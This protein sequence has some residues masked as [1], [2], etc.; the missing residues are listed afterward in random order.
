MLRFL[1]IVHAAL[2]HASGKY[3]IMFLTCLVEDGKDCSHSLAPYNPVFELLLWPLY[4]Y[5]VEFL[6][7]GDQ[8]SGN[9]FGDSRNSAIVMPLIM[10]WLVR[11][12]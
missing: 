8:M 3:Y 5:A 2:I 10:A 9:L 12:A 7:S 1:R 11:A 6:V 4:L